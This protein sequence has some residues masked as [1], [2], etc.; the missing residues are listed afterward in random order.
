MTKHCTVCGIEQTMDAFSKNAG[1]P[2]GYCYRCKSCAQ[3]YHQQPEQRERDR[4]CARMYARRKRQE[5]INRLGGQCAF[6]D[7]TE[8]VFLT[9]D[10]IHCDGKLHRKQKGNGIGVWLDI[11]KQGCPQ[12]KYRVLCMNCNHAL[13]LYG[14]IEVHAAIQRMKLGVENVPCV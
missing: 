13:F 4:Q 5:V 6:C 10:H 11:L 7:C 8:S 2:D 9:V 12:D 1:M 3:K 14:E